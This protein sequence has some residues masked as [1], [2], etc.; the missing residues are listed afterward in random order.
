MKEKKEEKGLS[1]AAPSKKGFF[2]LLLT[3]ET[4][5]KASDSRNAHSEKAIWRH[6]H[7]RKTSNLS[8]ETGSTRPFRDAKGPAEREQIEEQH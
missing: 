2:Y 4:K 3:R 1:C 8:Q 6:I 5:I 7:P